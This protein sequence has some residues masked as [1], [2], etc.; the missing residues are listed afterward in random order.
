MLCDNCH[1]RM[2]TIHL[3]Q[4]I[5]ND[6]VEVH[7]CENCAKEKNYMNFTMAPDISSFFNSLLGL[8]GQPYGNTPK[9]V[10]CE[11]CGMSFEDFKESGKFGCFNC[12]ETFA[13]RIEP[14]IK[15]IHGN[16]EHTGRVPQSYSSKTRKNC[17]DTE[18]SEKDLFKKELE[19]LIKQE[20]FEEAAKVRDKIKALENGKKE[21]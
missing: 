18:I 6:K 5:N 7:L 21:G 19:E 16:A 14:I 4:I 20:K 15:R 8:T 10:T 1:K 2:A 13:D 3:T 11:V 17:K 9:S 12:Y